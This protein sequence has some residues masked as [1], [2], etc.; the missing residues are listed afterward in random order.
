MGGWRWGLCI[1]SLWHS[2][3]S[4]VVLVAVGAEGQGVL[5]F[6]RRERLGVQQVRSGDKCRRWGVRDGGLTT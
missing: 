6:L 2:Y 5:G 3:L 4:P 1:V